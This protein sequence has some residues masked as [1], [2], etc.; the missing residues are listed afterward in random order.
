MSDQLNVA[1]FA[2]GCF[3]GVEH[4]FMKEKGVVK[5]A[6][7]YMAGK[8]QNPNYHDVKTGQTEHLEVVRV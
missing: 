2:A 7:G 6:V 4:Y 1:Y 3:W 8:T 5:T